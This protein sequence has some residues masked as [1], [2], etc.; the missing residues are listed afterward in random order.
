MPLR[1]FDKLLRDSPSAHLIVSPD[2]K[3]ITANEAY[4]ARTGLKPTDIG[5]AWYDVFPDNPHQGSSSIE[6]LMRSMRRVMETHKAD[7]MPRNHRYDLQADDGRWVERY[8]DAANTP[9]FE[10]GTFFGILHTLEDRTELVHEIAILQAQ[11]VSQEFAARESGHR[12]KNVMATVQYL[13]GQTLQS[14]T[15]IDEARKAFTQR[16]LALAQA[17]DLLIAENW[18]EADV[19]DVIYQACQ[20]F[21]GTGAI[22]YEGESQKLVPREAL[23]LS[24]ALH[25]LCTNSVKYGALSVASGEVTIAWR[26]VSDR[27]LVTWTERG[28]P[29]VLPPTRS[30]LGSK[31]LA[32]SG[33]QF[34][35]NPAGLVV[36]LW[37]K[38]G[39]D[40]FQPS[41]GA[42]QPA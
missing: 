32:S 38:T 12:L 28:G 11:L 6:P 22:H 18:I 27:L 10:K 35:W 24:M 39:P 25:E 26:H 4:T 41:N 29:P 1:S 23:Y 20:P 13:A 16:L 2:A 14:G 33:A 42:R 5:R 34:D 3:I 40:V 7:V 21:N 30:G 19:A 17:H 36:S 37:M 31:L 8:F 15:T 9:I